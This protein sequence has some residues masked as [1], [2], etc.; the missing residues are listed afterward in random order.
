[1]TFTTLLALAAALMPVP[2]L[3]GDLPTRTVL[4][5]DLDLTKFAG[6][7]RLDHRILAAA[8]SVCRSGDPRD[9]VAMTAIKKCRSAALASA[10]RQ[11]Q[12]AI[13]SARSAQKLASAG[14]ESPALR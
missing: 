11:T 1:M 7:T 3:A 5:S 9:L 8:R 2:A 13:A 14:R 10:Q 4:Y 6:I 12:L